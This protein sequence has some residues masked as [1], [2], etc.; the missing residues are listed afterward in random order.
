MHR[1]CASTV[2]YSLESRQFDQLILVGPMALDDVTKITFDTFTA[3]PADTFQLL[4]L[5][6]G[7]TSNRFSSF[8]APEEWTLSTDSL[9]TVPDPSSFVLVRIG[10]AL[11]SLRK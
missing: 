9:L 1:H 6:N 2:G 4:Y 3:G 10:L 5:I 11:L 8:V 7:T